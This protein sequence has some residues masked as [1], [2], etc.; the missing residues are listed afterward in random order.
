[1]GLRVLTYGAGNNVVFL[2]MLP[3]IGERVVLLEPLVA[4]LKTSDEVKGTLIASDV[5]HGKVRIKKVRG[6]VRA[7]KAKGRLRATKARGKV[8]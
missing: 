8:K 5:L 3:T 4:V 6:R 1:M 2:P 7:D